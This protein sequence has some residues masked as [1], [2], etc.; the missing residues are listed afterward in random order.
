MSM[1][2]T[3]VLALLSIVLFV[4]SAT[5][6]ERDIQIRSI[7]L[8]NAEEFKQAH[9]LKGTFIRPP[10]VWVVMDDL[11]LR[12]GDELD[13]FVIREID[14]YRVVFERDENRIVLEM[15]DT[16]GSQGLREDSR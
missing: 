15:S 14:H 9:T 2:E 4:A 12:V 11:I 10:D 13:G 8:Q 7:D 1:R 5:A 6:A 3:F 16:P